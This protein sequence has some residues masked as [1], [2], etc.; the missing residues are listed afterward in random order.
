MV[1]YTGPSIALHAGMTGWL[2]MVPLELIT[3]TNLPCREITDTSECDTD[4]PELHTAVEPYDTSTY[5]SSYG[6]GSIFYL[7]GQDD[8]VVDR[9]YKVD[10]QVVD[11]YKS[12]SDHH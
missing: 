6:N 12:V 11:L 2:Y 10:S 9:R 8:K 7:P 5:L 1:K 4:M 3:T